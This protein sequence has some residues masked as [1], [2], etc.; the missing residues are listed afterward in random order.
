[1]EI[2]NRQSIFHIETFNLMDSCDTL[3]PLMDQTMYGFFLDD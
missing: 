2:S 3:T 1:V